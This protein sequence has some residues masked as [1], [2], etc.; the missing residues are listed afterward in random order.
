MTG[1]GIE[2][3]QVRTGRRPEST[4]RFPSE[5]DPP[6]TV[7][8]PAQRYYRLVEGVI[9]TG[10]AA[11]SEQFPLL[12]QQPHKSLSGGPCPLTTAPRATRT[13]VT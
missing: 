13:T 4:Y 11:R 3:P 10:V 2:A 1:Q 7:G 8:E 9:S 6:S 12:A 5:S